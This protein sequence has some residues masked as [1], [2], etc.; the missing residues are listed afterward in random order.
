MELIKQKV[1]RLPGYLEWIREQYCTEPNCHGS[2]EPH[3]IRKNT[4]GGIGL[5][6]SDNY[7]IPLCREHHRMWHDNGTKK[8][9]RATHD[10]LAQAAYL[11]I[12]YLLEQ[13]EIKKVTDALRGIGAAMKEI[14]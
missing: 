5:K 3:H 11:N 9:V 1:I 8:S 2:V 10:I 6:P 14:E 12:L 7:V 13:G 4:D